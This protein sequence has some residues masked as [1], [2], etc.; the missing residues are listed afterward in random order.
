MSKAC[1]LGRQKM[2]LMEMFLNHV[3]QRQRRQ[4]VDVKKTSE[5]LENPMQ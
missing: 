1:E 3:F 4:K 2:L 5:V